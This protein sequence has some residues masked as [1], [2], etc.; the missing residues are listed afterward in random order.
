MAFLRRVTPMRTRAESLRWGK[1]RALGE[2]SPFVSPPAVPQALG[3]IATEGRSK[4]VA[5]DVRVLNEVSAEH[6]VQHRLRAS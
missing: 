1:R 4:L 3:P 6:D 5:S 2:S